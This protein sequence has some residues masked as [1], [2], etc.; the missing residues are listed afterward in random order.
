M[1]LA[2]KPNGTLTT[3]SAP[4]AEFFEG[5]G[6]TRRAATEL[7]VAIEI[8]LTLAGFVSEF[9]KFGTRPALDI[10]AISIGF[11]AVRA[12]G[13]F[14]DVRVAFGAVAPTP[15]RAPRT[16]TAL[17]GKPLAAALNAALDAAAADIAP[18]SD[19]RASEWYR[20]E[21]VRNILRRMLEHVGER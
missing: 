7:L 11:G 19:I 4:L 3:R 10:A 13:T 20:R 1:V 15:I 2:S 9:Y 5:P 6:R 17:E 8:P 14:V 18:I 21:L 12:K 16:E